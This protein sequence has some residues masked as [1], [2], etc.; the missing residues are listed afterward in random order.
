MRFLRNSLLSV[1]A[2]VLLWSC[3]STGPSKQEMILGTW[4][5]DFQGQSMTLTYGPEEITVNEFGISFPYEWVSEDEIRLDAL[6]QVVTSRVDFVSADEM[7]QTSDQGV[8]TLT[9]VVQ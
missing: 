3:A 2:A 9:R 1:S 8:Q 7:T 6:G 4:S 5:A